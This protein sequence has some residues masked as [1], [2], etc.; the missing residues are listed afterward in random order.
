[1][2]DAV[3][4]TFA[5]LAQGAT[6]LIGGRPFTIS[7]TGGDGNDVVLTVPGAAPRTWDG[8]GGDD[9]WM[10]AAN[11]QDDLGPNPGDQLVFAG[12]VRLTPNNNFPTNTPFHSI[13]FNAGGFNLTGNAVQLSGT[14]TG[15]GITNQTGTNTIT[16]PLNVMTN[17]QTIHTTDLG[18][19]TLT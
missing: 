8:G 9:N 18:V 4:G 12:T 19:L 5:G 11:W 16:L 1:G 13:T 10:T 7:Y 14:G 2:T 17:P 3:V 6:V 15:A